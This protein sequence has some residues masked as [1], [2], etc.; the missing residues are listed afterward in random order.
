M[1]L[2]W[3][4][5]HD[6]EGKFMTW[7]RSWSACQRYVTLTVTDRKKEKTW[8]VAQYIPYSDDHP[9]PSDTW[10]WGEGPLPVPLGQFKTMYEARMACEQDLETRKGGQR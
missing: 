1:A 8:Y 3:L 5:S 2:K 9:E 7:R 4:R 6:A 10:R